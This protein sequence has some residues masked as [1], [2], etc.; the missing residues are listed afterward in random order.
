MSEVAEIFGPYLANS[1][2]CVL[3]NLEDDVIQLDHF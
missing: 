3:L 1:E 2:E